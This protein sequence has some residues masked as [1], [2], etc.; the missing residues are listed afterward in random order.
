MRRW[1]AKGLSMNS[2]MAGRAAGLAFL[3]V[4]VSSPALA[5]TRYMLCFGGGRPGLYYSNVFPVPGGT[6]DADKAKAFNALVSA[7]Y[8]VKISSECHTDMT[9]ASGTSDKKIREQSDQGSKYPSKL[10][11]T[12]WPAK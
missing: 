7:K 11:E 2:G 8:H 4:V 12:G 5:D 10:V 1:I 9:L 6:K 3:A